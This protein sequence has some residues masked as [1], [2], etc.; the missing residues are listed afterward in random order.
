MLP[1]PKAGGVNSPESE[2][3]Q[4]GQSGGTEDLSAS[5]ASIAHITG[6]AVL[7]WGTVQYEGQVVSGV[8]H[9]HGTL[10]WADRREFVGDFADGLF[11]GHGRMQW[12]DGRVFLGQYLKNSKHGHGVFTWPDGREYAGQW[13]D[14]KRHGMGRYTNAKGECRLGHWVDDKPISWERTDGG[15]NPA[16]PRSLAVAAGDV[17][18]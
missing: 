12:P 18:V 11:H 3:T 15:P 1:G 8:K 6:H 14:G 16:T 7:E 13:C 10:R 2:S 5:E 9:G 4:E 17:I